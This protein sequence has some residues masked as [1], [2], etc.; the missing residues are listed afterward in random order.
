MK[1]RELLKTVLGASLL[2]AT[3]VVPLSLNGCKEKKTGNVR[4]K[5]TFAFFTDVHLL[6]N[7]DR[8]SHIGFQ[9]ALDDVLPKGVDFIL[10]GGDNIDAV[11]L[12][13]READVLYKWFKK[14]VDKRGIKAHYTIGNHDAHYS[15]ID[16]QSDPYGYKLHEKYFG[17]LT[18]SFD[19]KGVH[20]IV[21]NS[22]GRHGKGYHLGD[23]QCD[24]LEDDLKT[25]G[26]E[27]PVVVSMHVP[28]QSLYY[29]AVEGK[30][31]STDMIT[32][33]KKVWDILEQYNVKIVLQGHQHL[34]EELFV[35]DM[36]FLTGGAVCGGWWAPG[37]FYK[38][39]KGY[40]LIHVDENNNFTWEYNAFVKEKEGKERWE[41]TQGAS[42][43]NND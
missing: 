33:F 32:D 4:R 42:Q 18:Y 14:E 2:T 25:T 36:K 28:I 21:L 11:S 6:R 9:R 26:Q 27:I 30:I 17:E 38:T 1:R 16:R 31:V 7:N 23:A 20:F 24:W 5:F 13:E 34:H 15:P 22:V 37:D 10:F 29:P 3:G 43:Y 8:N 35:K 19:H 41:Y 12:S 40:M 39:D